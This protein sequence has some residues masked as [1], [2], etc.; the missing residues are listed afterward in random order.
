MKIKVIIID[1][2]INYIKRIVNA[3]T[4]KYAGAVEFSSFSNSEDA[5]VQLMHIK[6][7]I[8]LVS[9][10][11]EFDFKALPE[12]CY[13]AYLCDSNSVR[14]F[15]NEKAI[16]KYRKID[17]FY[18]SLVEMYTHTVDDYLVDEPKNDNASKLISF[19][20]PAGGVG[21]STISIAY[22]LKLAKKGFNVLYISLEKFSSYDFFFDVDDEFTFSDVI[23]AV[24]GNKANLSLK[25]ESIIK[26]SSN[27]VYYIPACKTALD[28]F[29]IKYDELTLLIKTIMN[30]ENYDY[31]VLDC[32]FQMSDEDKFILNNSKSAFIISDGSYEANIKIERFIKACRLLEDSHKYCTVSDIKII[33]NKCSGNTSSKI[34]NNEITEAGSIKKYAGY[35]QGEL[36]N[37]ISADMNIL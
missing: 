37:V 26:K 7:N 11:I 23:K 34:E 2:D 6:P 9:E 10:H 19:F 22:A 5:I 35:T 15:K 1:K 25:I 32:D 36:F 4:Q 13:A 30:M 17:D 14:M 3:L 12:N 28:M 33:Y 27:G 24:K 21:V 20:S 16:G 31:V 18:S 8:V 29:N